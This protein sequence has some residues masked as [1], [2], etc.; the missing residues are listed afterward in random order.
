M[1]SGQLATA[2]KHLRAIS[3]RQGQVCR[4]EEEAASENEAALDRKE[5]LR[6]WHWLRLR[7]CRGKPAASLASVDLPR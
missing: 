3:V 2:Q 1:A 6:G 4:A 7:A 5:V